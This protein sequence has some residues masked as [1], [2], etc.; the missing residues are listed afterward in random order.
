MY[1]EQLVEWE[2]AGETDV[3]GENLPQCHFVKHKSH[4]IYS[5]IKLGRR[6]EKPATNHL[7][8]STARD[9]VSRPY[10]TNN[11]IM[12]G[13]MQLSS[14]KESCLPVFVCSLLSSGQKRAVHPQCVTFVFRQ[15]CRY[16]SI[17]WLYA[18][19]V[20]PAV[21]GLVS[22]MFLMPSSLPLTLFLNWISYSLQFQCG[23][24]TVKHED[25]RIWNEEVVVF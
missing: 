20:V 13:F 1:M 8:H 22:C 19:R 12:Y 17:V 16:T 5:G 6:G 24:W 25:G 14:L 2:L 10:R 15:V 9:K 18:H 7:S 11:R 4:M 21:K 3:L 23:R